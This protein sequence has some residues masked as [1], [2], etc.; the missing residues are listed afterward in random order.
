M[1]ISGPLG[2]AM[3][4]RY[5]TLACTFFRSVRPYVA[6]LS[7]IDI[8]GEGEM[9]RHGIFFISAESTEILSFNFHSLLAPW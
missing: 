2:D 9:D 1:N 3:C 4:T 7:L 6:L 5:V 8:L